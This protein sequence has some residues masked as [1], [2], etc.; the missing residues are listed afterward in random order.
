MHHANSDKNIYV[1][2]LRWNNKVY[3]KNYVDHFDL[4]KGGVLD[5][6]M[7]KKPNKNRGTTPETYP[8]SFSI[9]K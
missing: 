8:Y 4:L 3:N 7:D 1:R 6:S 9:N 5:F 2:E